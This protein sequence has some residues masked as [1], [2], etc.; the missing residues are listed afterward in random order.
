MLGPFPM[1]EFA[2]FKNNNSR[3][4]ASDS[5]SKTTDCYLMP[6]M[7]LGLIL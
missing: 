2:F 6:R 7:E 4:L 5:N 1:K 3:H